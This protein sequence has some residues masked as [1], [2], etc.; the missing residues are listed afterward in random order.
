MGHNNGQN[1]CTTAQ[2]VSNALNLAND[3]YYDLDTN[4]YY[5][6]NPNSI[7]NTPQEG[8]TASSINPHPIDSLSRTNGRGYSD[9]D[10]DNFTTV[11]YKKHRQNRNNYINK[12]NYIQQ[13]QQH[14][15]TF[16]TNI[17]R[18][19]SPPPLN[20]QRIITNSNFLPHDHAHRAS[21]SRFE[22]TMA[23]TRYAQTR[24]PF[25]PFIIR[26]SAGNIKDKQVV[27]EVSSHVKKHY[28][29][30]LY[31]INYR[32]SIA[33]CSNNE[34]DILLYVKDS[35]SF[36]CLLDQ[37]KW[38]S[39]IGNENYIFPSSPS[40]PPQLSL[41][42]KN[43]DFHTDME[44]FIKDLKEKYPDVKNVIRLKNKFQ[45][46]IRTIKIELVSS[47]THS[48]I[49]ALGKINVNYRSYDV[50]EFIAP[51][52]V[53]ICS[54]CCGIGHFKRQCSQINETCKTCGQS[55]PDLKQHTCTNKPRCIHCGGDHSSNVS[56]C[57]VVKQFRAA[58]T[59]K[60]LSTTNKTPTTSYNFK[61]DPAQF[62]QLSSTQH[63]PMF[64]ANSKIILKL[65][66]LMVNI[67]KMNQNIMSISKCNEKF[68]KFMIDKINSDKI[69]AQDI[70]LLKN[71]DKTLE[72]NQVQHELKLKRIDNILTKLVLPMVD[73]MTKVVLSQYQDQHERASDSNRR[74]MIESIRAKLKTV[75]D[76]N[77]QS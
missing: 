34:Y 57:P 8:V 16:D 49:L 32:S 66:E 70:E 38:P 43:V 51:V 44:D 75:M 28:Q 52:S 65:D 13:Q 77:D 58:L 15:S 35:D 33:K 5:H 14:H 7:R 63:A 42:I 10:E 22:I 76:G 19:S 26:F 31:F 27:E 3:F 59:K 30:D 73:E 45:Q 50:E 62:P 6:P 39:Q 9:D 17:N 25:P 23:A 60:I 11:T 53:L 55:V 72:A 64:G 37:Q 36:T 12:H 18:N 68:E 24:F 2:E 29:T 40:I 41:I 21:Q 20:N 56:S 54:K 47:D 74:S 67:E 4:I 71:H 61:Y 48:Q 1:P 46:D 69:I